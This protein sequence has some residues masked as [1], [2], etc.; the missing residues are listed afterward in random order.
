MGARHLYDSLRVSDSLGNKNT[1]MPRV[2]A[3]A[4]SLSRRP[5]RRPICACCSNQ[6]E[7][8]ALF[9]EVNA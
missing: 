5:N 3:L 9:Y 8:V 6:N 1:Y 7:T 4:L 2:R